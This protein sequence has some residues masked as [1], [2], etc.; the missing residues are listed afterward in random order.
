MNHADFDA[1]QYPYRLN[2]FGRLSVQEM[3]RRNYEKNS[4]YIF[5]DNRQRL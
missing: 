2:G 3:K 5:D 4:D 1:T